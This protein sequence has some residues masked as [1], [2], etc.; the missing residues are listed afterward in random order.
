MAVNV[1]RI[2]KEFYSSDTNI[3]KYSANLKYILGEQIIEIEQMNIKSIAIDSDY[4][5]MKMPMI[6]L[7]CSVHRD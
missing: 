5:N 6:M 4:K 7:T 3:Y 1:N 2:D